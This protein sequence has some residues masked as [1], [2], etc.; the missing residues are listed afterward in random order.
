MNERLSGRKMWL[1]YTRAQ[2]KK[3]EVKEI[4]NMIERDEHSSL[5]FVLEEL[6]K[7]K[8]KVRPYVCIQHPGEII[9]IPEKILHHTLNIGDGHQMVHGWTA[10]KPTANI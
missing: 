10:I 2:Q 4:L 1:F 9:L 8:P 5:S 3:R 7:L 6:P